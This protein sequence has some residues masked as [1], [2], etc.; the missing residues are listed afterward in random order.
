MKGKI[1]HTTLSLLHTCKTGSI[2]MDLI[3][4]ESG[5]SKRTLYQLFNNKEELIQT[6]VIYR[7]EQEQL[8][9]HIDWGVLDM[10]LDYFHSFQHL[11]LA[12]DYQCCQN[13]R[14]NNEEIYRYL[15]KQIST[16]AEL[17]KAKI[18]D[19][20]SRGYIRK[21]IP[22]ELVYTFI[23]SH[24]T[25]LFD[26]DRCLLHNYSGKL[27]AEMVLCFMRG[28]TTAKGRGYIEQQLKKHTN[29]TN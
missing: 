27:M 20:I 6:C 29:E 15:L 7:L 25:S 9:A 14:R 1:I 22:E 4:H 12:G 28:I 16:Y 17:C 8:F 2:T 5:I 21:D 3:S 26:D 10:M 19:S 24:F 11:P 23:M 13:I 18:S